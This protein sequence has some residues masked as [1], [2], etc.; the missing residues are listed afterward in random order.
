MFKIRP[1]P[2]KGLGLFATSA[3]PRGTRILSET[4]LLSLSHTQDSSQIYVASTLITVKAREALLALSSH[5]TRE[6]RIIRSVQ[7]A[8]AISK[9]SILDLIKGKNKSVRSQRK[10]SWLERFRQHQNIT[11]VFRSNAFNIGHRSEGAPYHQA[12]FFTIS[13]INHS[14]I[15]NAQAN[16]HPTLQT[17]NVHA[18]RD[19]EVDEEVT[20]NYLA[21]SGAGRKVRREALERDYGFSCDC[22]ACGADV[23]GDRGEERRVAMSD[24]VKEQVAGMVEG[25]IDLEIE[26]KTTIKFA[27]M[28]VG[29]GLAG[30]EVSSL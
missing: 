8:I 2:H 28:L 21:E 22:A 23:I 27:E 26:L 29:E 7:A 17:F 25:K 3:I 18:I 10:T 9:I 15:P 13:R 19:I 6:S 16:F 20:I 11:N 30:R 14:C 24:Y 12:V 4:P 1:T 5:T